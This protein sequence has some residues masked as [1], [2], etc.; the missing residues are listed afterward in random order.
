MITIKEVKECQIQGQKNLILKGLI[1]D[2][3]C[4][5]I[6]PKDKHIEAFPTSDEQDSFTIGAFSNHDLKG[7]ASFMRDG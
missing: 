3:D 4:F 5:R 6:A 7:V 1:E 2:E